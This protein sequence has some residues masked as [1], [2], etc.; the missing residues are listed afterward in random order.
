MGAIPWFGSS[1]NL[2][3][4]GSTLVEGWKCTVGIAPGCSD[5][6]IYFALFNFTF[7]LST[8]GN[9]FLNYYSPAMTSM[10][11]Q[12]SSP[13]TALTLIIIP[14]WNVTGKKINIPESLVAV[15]LITIG[16]LCYTVWEESTRHADIIRAKSQRSRRSASR[17]AMAAAEEGDVLPP[18]A[19]K[20]YGSV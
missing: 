16:S 9:T 20:T 8:V 3:S 13:V 12:L 4:L 2:S 14:A 11:S 6:W 10:I 7:V 17:R 18:L 5:S 1:A 19:T 15:V